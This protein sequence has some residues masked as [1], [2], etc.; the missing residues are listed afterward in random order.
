MERGRE[1]TE[2]TME[3]PGGHAV[4]VEVRTAGGD[5]AGAVGE[6]D[7]RLPDGAPDAVG[8]AGVAQPIEEVARERD[9]LR[10]RLLRTAADFDNYRKRVERDRRE[11][12]EWAAA[13]LL[14]AL[15]PIVDDLE[16]ALGADAVADPE[17]FRKGVELIHRQMLDLLARRGVVPIEAVGAAFDPRWHE[18][19]VHEPDDTRPPGEVTAELRRGYKLG[20]RLLRAS[21]VKVAGA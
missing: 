9:D 2:T 7:E 18:A 12:A 16:R 17:A 19:V 14:G 5:P 8:A 6:P 4:R 15:L 11:Q 1:V 13:D 21:M 3:T 10:D 20:D